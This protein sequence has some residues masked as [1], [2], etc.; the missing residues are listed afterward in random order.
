MSEEIVPIFGMH[1]HIAACVLL[2]I[3][4]ELRER[5]ER[6]MRPETWESPKRDL[7]DT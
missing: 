2:S 7:R 3:V 4:R 6:V 5:A 1:H